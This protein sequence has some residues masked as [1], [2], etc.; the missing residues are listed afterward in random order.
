MVIREQITAF[1]SFFKVSRET[2]YSLKKY[3]ELIINANKTLNLIGKSTINRIWE[4]HILDSFQVIDFIDKNDISITD[5]GS[6]A[7]FPGIVLA[8]AAE[9]RNIPLKINLID[10][11][12]KKKIFLESAIKKLNL[13]AEVVC[14]NIFDNEKKLI[15]D[16]FVARAFKPLP[17][18][19]KLINNKA[20]YFNKFFIFLGKTGNKQLLEASKSWDI[21]YKQR[22]SV[23]SGDS[24]IIEVRK[25]KKK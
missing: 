4:R 17:I 6:G 8:I 13:N 3:E 20:I 23:T 2:I 1:S 5:L 24:I 18:I 12:K 9:D 15:G 7:G 25:L 21:E 16:V 10:K 19:L 11:S 14:E 22:V